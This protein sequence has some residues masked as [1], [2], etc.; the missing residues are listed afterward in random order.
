M[1][2]KVS[3]F[4]IIIALFF[5]WIFSG[6]PVIWQN[7]RI[8]PEIS[9]A[10]AAG[11]IRQDYYAESLGASTTTAGTYEDKVTLSFTPDD[12]STYLLLA[13]WVMK[14]SGTSYEVKGR[15]ERTTGTSKTFNVQT[16][17]PKDAT[18]YIAGG[19]VAIDTFGSSPGSQTYKIQYIITSG[20]TGYIKD[21]KVIAIKLGDNDEYAQDEGTSTTQSTSYQDK[22]TLTF[23]PDSQGDYVILA[24]AGIASNN[25]NY[26][27]RAQLTIDGTAYSNVNIEPVTY[28]NTYWWG[29][30]KRVNLTAASHTIKI[31]YSIENATATAGIKDARIVVLRADD[32]YNNYYS[33]SETRV[34]T[35][36]TSYVDT[37]A[38]VTQ[39][40]PE[41]DYL[42][43]GSAGLDGR[44]ASYSAYGQLIK[45]SSTSYG[46][47]LLE[48]QDTT[49]QGYGYFSIKKESLT[50]TSYNWKIQYKAESGA[51]GRDAGIKNMRIS[52]IQ[53]NQPY[54]TVGITGTQTSNIEA[55][56][57]NNYV[58]GA[59]TFVRNTGSAN[60]TQIVINEEG[61]VSANSN[62]SNLDIYYETAGTCTYDGNETLFGT[63]S[64]FNSSDQATITGTMA[65]GTSQV[66]VYAVL[67]VGSGASASETIELEISTPGSDVTV[68]SGI[69][70]GTSAVQISGTSTIIKP[71]VTIGTTGTQTTN[72]NADS[73]NNYIG[74]AFTAVRSASST[75]ITQI[76]VNEKGTVSADSNLSN[77]DLYYET[78]GTCTY[79]GDETLFGTASS[80]SSEAATITG[81]IATG[82]SQICI[83]AVLDVGSGASASETI[84]LEISNPSTDVT[85][86]SGIV[87]GTSAVQISGT[88]TILKPAITV[89][90]TGTQTA[91]IYNSTN[92]NYIGGAFTFVRGSGS[93]NITQIIINEEGTVNANNNLSNLDIYYETAG[94]CTYD[95]NE[96]LFGT[97]SSF[98]SS[99]QATI[100]GTMAVGTS[101]VCVYA[102]LDV[103]SGPIGDQTIE[104]EISN[105]ST[106]VTV[107]SGIVD[108]TSPVQISGTSIIV[109]VISVSID[110]GDVQYGVLD[111]NA[112]ADTL[113]SQTQT[114]TNNGNV[115]EDFEIK[116]YN[117]SGGG[118]TWTLVS[119]TPS[120]DQYK[121]EFSTNSGSNWSSLT[122]GYS[123]LISS[124]TK[125]S[126]FDLD[127]KITMPS[128]SSCYN[129]QSADMTV[130]ALESEL[131]DEYARRKSITLSNSGSALTNYQIEVDVTYDSDMQADFDDIRFTGSDGATELDFWLESKTDSTSAVFWVEVPSIPNGNSTIYMYYGN[132]SVTS[133]SNGD[134]TFL[135]FDDFNGTSL[136][137]NKWTITKQMGTGTITVTGGTLTLNAPGGSA[138]NVT[139]ESNYSFSESVN[140]K[141]K[142][143]FYNITSQERNRGLFS[144]Y[145]VPGDAG[146][147][148]SGTNV[149]REFFV[150]SYY[151]T[152]TNEQW[153]DSTGVI[154]PNSA[155]TSSW[156]LVGTQTWTTSV[157]PCK[158]FASA[159][160]DAG[161]VG[162]KSEY[163]SC[164]FV[165][166]LQQSRLFLLGEPKKKCLQEENQLRFLTLDR[167]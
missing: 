33:E 151:N 79:D 26:D 105:P 69:V 136:D 138:N 12:N 137:T 14:S 53:L 5:A 114:V 160:D 92:N 64:S 130:L 99:D 35:Q 54:I 89:G 165:N 88:T 57:T 47:M 112:T 51:T 141:A 32:F 94:T 109:K 133:S 124:I 15:L 85:V 44:S 61:T 11:S 87:S 34:T 144:I 83:Y 150:S 154:R 13:S 98:N 95:G 166:L 68:S 143:K 139:I 110:D 129:Q 128:S 162:G 75:N 40:T 164:L 62:L 123:E 103:G 42:I 74:G 72:V 120:T 17:F 39:T 78:A 2:R 10:L 111:S 101:Q 21:A 50:N 86:S 71:Y 102:V 126:D 41:G 31:Q 147:F 131:L 76:I 23:T 3:I 81:T 29:M 4:F 48:T 145:G 46:E 93:A 140:T 67:D 118:C 58:G 152:L 106:D 36:S 37:S 77:L 134:N 153:Y 146:V 24:G 96:T 27:V 122:T 97:A 107:S 108:G 25:V 155:G 20:G 116:G 18:D 7:P 70:S 159:G 167:L 115:K 38:S 158:V 60:I 149:L 80:F 135:L 163:D 82:T 65:V 30:V 113:S 55:P 125:G 157:T 16:Y 119:G 49:N 45:D 156:T 66:C 6:W 104:L 9:E 142:V 56:S 91:N 121:H 1:S 22:T 148:D 100:T 52:V 161:W 127:L 59:F 117:A 28:Y 63:A 90:T 73:T 84:E 43:I 8:P 19:A 132:S